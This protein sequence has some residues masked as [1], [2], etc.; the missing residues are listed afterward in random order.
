MA[1]LSVIDRF[2]DIFSRYIDSGFGLLGGEV[3]FLSST[4]VAIDIVLAGLAWA[5]RSEEHALAALTR[6][7]LYVGAFAFI[8]GNFRALADIIFQSFSGIGLKAGGGALSAADLMRPGIVA[9]TGFSAAHPLLVELSDLTGFPDVFVHLPT[10]VIILFSWIMIV[11]SF[12][13]LS[14]QLF[15]TII[16]FKITTL[17]GFILVPFALW[18]KTAFLAEKTLGNVVSSGIKVM[19]LAIVVGIGSTI[20]DGLAS[21]LTSPIDIAQAMSLLLASLSLLGLGIF[22]PSVAAGLASGA[23]HL[24][25]GA[26]ATTVAGASAITYAGSA[27]A[28]SGARLV[29]S[30]TGSALRRA[31][32]LG[33]AGSAAL[34]IGRSQSQKL[35]G[36]VGAHAAHAGF[37]TLRDQV[38]SR[39]D[40]WITQAWDSGA[41]QVFRANWQALGQE[42]RSTPS[43]P[44][45]RPG[46]G[47]AGNTGRHLR[48]AGRA[49]V[50]SLREGDH[51]GHSTGPSL[52][53]E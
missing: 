28:F 41:E 36:S 45:E 9:S 18:G 48:E 53:E 30:A 12:F 24:G 2:T 39:A 23:P 20:F 15:V 7:V 29:G 1:D 17:A 44:P 37:A 8:L 21:G 10:I 52:R 6:K 43:K 50:R 42:E 47:G 26:A 51:P 49:A 4:L 34:E 33:G 5:M 32:S 40:E 27:L 13:V 31:A 46:T 19:V 11:L 22:S 35:G 14:V 16:E 25:A 38:E 3:S